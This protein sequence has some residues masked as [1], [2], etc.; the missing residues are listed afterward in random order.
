MGYAV[1]DAAMRQFG[2]NRLAQPFDLARVGQ[3]PALRLKS[4]ESSLGVS[5]VAVLRRGVQCLPR[6]GARIRTVVA[7]RFVNRARHHL[8]QPVIHRL[9]LPSAP[10]PAPQWRL[11]S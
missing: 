9:P 8:Y 11:G 6:G 5:A 7:V 4:S 3:A 2:A 10:S 1:N